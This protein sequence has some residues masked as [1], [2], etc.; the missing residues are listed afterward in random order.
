MTGMVTTKGFAVRQG[1][2]F[3]INLQIHDEKRRPI[4]LSGATLIMQVRDD[5]GNLMFQCLGTEVDVVNGKMA[6]ILTPDM[7]NIAVGDYVTDIQL[8][9]NDGSVN[10]I[11]PSDVGTVGVFRITEQVTIYNPHE[12]ENTET[13]ENASDEEEGDN[14]GLQS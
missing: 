5:S 13:F 3:T 9:T 8:N 2:S 1:D 4:D 6:L 12:D 10:T 11:F 14:N 7:T